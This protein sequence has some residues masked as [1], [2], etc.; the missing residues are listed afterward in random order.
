MPR[1]AVAEEITKDDMITKRRLSLTLA[2]SLVASLGACGGS[3]SDSPAGADADVKTSEYVP[4]SADNSSSQVAR[5]ALYE[6]IVA[7]RKADGFNAAACGDLSSPAAGTL[8]EIYTRDDDGGGVLQAK[9]QGRKDDHSYNLDATIGVTMDTIITEAITDCFAGNLEPKFAGQLVD[10]TLQWFFYASVYHELVLGIEGAEDKWDEAYGYY[11]L[12]DGESPR[13][14]AV[15]AIKRDGNFG[16]T[17][18]ETL[19]DLFIEGHEVISSTELTPMNQLVKT[20]DQNLLTVFA[21]STAREFADL[22]T[23]EEPGVKLAEGMA[24]FNIIEAQM[25]DASASDAEFVRAQL[26]AV[27]FDAPTSIDAAGIQSRIETS[28]GITVAQ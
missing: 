11:G 3:D 4:F 7:A 25:K 21:Y 2:T 13:G 12:G 14:I 6:E 19:L 27:T 23:D 18:S 22:P 15:T 17:F 24:F 28:F 9:V 8:A 1:Y 26:D 5:V 20:M 16:T 10:K